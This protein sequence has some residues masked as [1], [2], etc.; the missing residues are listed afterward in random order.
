[1]M[2]KKSDGNWKDGA[3][4]FIMKEYKNFILSTEH[5]VVAGDVLHT[6]L[7]C[8]IKKPENMTAKA[9]KA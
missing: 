5:T 7:R 2:I 4:V 1:M 3:F 6:Y 8:G 9:F